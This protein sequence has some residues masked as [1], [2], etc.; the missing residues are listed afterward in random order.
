MRPICQHMA[1]SSPDFAMPRTLLTALLMLSMLLPNVSVAQETPT[2]PSPPAWLEALDALYDADLRV[3]GLEERDFQPE[4]W[5]DV[6]LPLATGARG[7]QVEEIGRSVE[8][9]P[10]RHVSWGKGK[11][12][13]FLWSQM[14]GDESTASMALA[15]LFRFLGEHPEHPLVQR[16]RE[17]TSLHFMPIVNPDG[18]ARFMCSWDTTGQDVND[19]V[20]DLKSLLGNNG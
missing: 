8:D 9:R 17:R 7:F 14:H 20:S 15:D 11:T 4:Q 12:S 6:A 19:F 16:L 13:V 5:W 2:M 18:A 1:Q 10:L 3:A